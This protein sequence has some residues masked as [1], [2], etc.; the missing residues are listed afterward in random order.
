MTADLLRLTGEALYGPQWQSA[1][2]RDLRCSIRTMQ[3]YAAGTREP[4][5]SM[6]QELREMVIERKSVLADMVPHLGV[7][8]TP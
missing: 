1:L 3:R 8:A 6:W 5:P 4:P 7:A 2:A